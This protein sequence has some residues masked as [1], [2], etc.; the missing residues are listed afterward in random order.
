MEQDISHLNPNNGENMKTVSLFEKEEAD[1]LLETLGLTN[2][3]PDET[4]DS[5][6]YFNAWHFGKTPEDGDYVI[7]TVSSMCENATIVVHTN[8]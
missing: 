3:T 8:D 2:N 6:R 4:D 7:S 1:K 5:S